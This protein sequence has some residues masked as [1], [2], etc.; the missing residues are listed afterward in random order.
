MRNNFIESIKHLS[1]QQQDWEQVYWSYESYDAGTNTWTTTNSGSIWEG[2]QVDYFSVN[3]YGYNDA[4]QGF[5]EVHVSSDYESKTGAD[6]NQ[7]LS[8][9]TA[10]MGAV[11]EILGLAD[12]DLQIFCG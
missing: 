10:G 4:L 6:C 3:Q 5:L 8:A 11:G 2:H 1:V 7:V 9:L 12:A